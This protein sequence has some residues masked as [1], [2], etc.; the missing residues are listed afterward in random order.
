MLCNVGRHEC[1]DGV[2]EQYIL[3]NQIYS[4]LIRLGSNTM[5]SLC[6][7]TYS[8]YYALEVTSQQVKDFQGL[9]NSSYGI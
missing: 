3:R 6:T 4:K 9:Y 8:D 1:V 2:Q 7:Y 5:N